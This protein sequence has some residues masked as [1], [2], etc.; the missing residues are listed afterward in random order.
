MLLKIPINPSSGIIFRIFSAQN[1]QTS[2]KSRIF[3]HETRSS[4]SKLH[5][6]MKRIFLTAFVLAANAAMAQTDDISTITTPV[7]SDLFPTV[8]EIFDFSPKAIQDFNDRSARYEKVL[9]AFEA[10]FFVSGSTRPVHLLCRQ[11]RRPFLRNRMGG[12]QGR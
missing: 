7:A 2:E 6:I 12:R 5:T 1:L 3:A 9:K 4:N 10:G 8:G 11:C